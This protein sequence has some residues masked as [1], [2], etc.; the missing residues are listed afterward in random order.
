MHKGWVHWIVHFY[1]Q[2]GT[3]S[4]R[5]G[6]IYSKEISFSMIRPA[7]AAKMHADEQAERLLAD[8]ITAMVLLRS[9]T[10][11]YALLRKS[12][13]DRN[14]RQVNEQDN[15]QG[16]TEEDDVQVNTKEDDAQDIDD[17]IILPQP[18]TRYFHA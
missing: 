11:E 16:N 15:V 3:D 13:T 17:K 14:Y 2:G 8:G 4:P 7:A 5:V 18:S 1:R 10:A 6:W 12:L 9:G